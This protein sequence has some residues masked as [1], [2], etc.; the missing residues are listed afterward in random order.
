MSDLLETIDTSTATL[1]KQ[2]IDRLT[3]LEQEKK[4]LSQDINEIYAEAKSNGFDTKTIK[5]ILSILKKD[6]HQ[7]AEEEA[8]LETYKIALGLI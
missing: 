6:Q 5:K 2:Y 1:L 3:R 7:I 4:D 8:L